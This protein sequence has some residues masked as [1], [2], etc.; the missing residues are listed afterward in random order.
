MTMTA[1]TSSGKA[2]RTIQRPR[3][4]ARVIAW[5]LRR[6]QASRIFWL[7]A[8]GFFGLALLLVWSQKIPLTLNHAQAVVPFDGYLAETSAWG[9]LRT[10]STGL[11]L[12]LGMLLPF[13]N[14]DGAAR[15]LSRRTYELLMATA[16]P[17]RV[18][19]WGRYLSGL[20][21]SLGLTLLTLVA[22]LGMGWFWHLKFADYPMP[23]IGV[24]LA[25]W[26]GLIVPATIV[27][28]GLSF[29][30]STLLP[31]LTILV[32][33]AL[34]VA[35]FV[36]AEMPFIQFGD[37][38]H[39]ASFS[40]PAWY[41]NWDPTGTGIALGLF[42]R[43][44]TAFSNLADRAGTTAQTQ[45]DL[46]AVENSL[47]DLGGWFGPHLLLAGLSLALVLIVALVFKRTRPTLN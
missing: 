42:N 27:V 19:L 4:I 14:A 3:L 17:T 8:L 9:L 38:S 28:S 25:V 16:L 22:L 29:A 1:L 6:F 33:V 32:K 2:T 5:E 39:S 31:R 37:A 12:L 20:L 43:Y 44:M 23:D 11:L 35:W 18:Y 36:G 40:L 13:I 15:D 30:L 10:L 21:L 24:L 45:L 7:Q 47:L 46:L 41:V 34:M 26:G